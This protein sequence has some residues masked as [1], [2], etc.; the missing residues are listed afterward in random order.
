MVLY[1][2]LGLFALFAVGVF[3]FVQSGVQLPEGADEIINHTVNQPIP[4]LV[5]G[6]TSLAKSGELDIWYERIRPDG[7]SRGTVLLVMGHNSTSML[8]SA[9]FYQPFVDQG[10]EVIRYDNRD[11]GLSSWVRKWDRK[12]PYSLE[13]MARDGIAVLDDAGVNKAH[14]I[15]ASMGGMIAQ[16]MA[17]SH[18]ERIE[19]LTSIMSTGYMMDP[20]I[21]PVPKWFAQNFVRFGIRYLMTGNIKGGPKFF[22]AILQTLRGNGPYDIDVKGASETMLYETQKRR[23]FNKRAIYQ[24]GKAIEVSGSRLEELSK[25]KTRTL[26][27]HGK[28]DPLIIFDH[29]E[30]YAAV[31]PHADKLFIEGMGHDIPLIYLDQVH[32]AIFKNVGITKAEKS[33]V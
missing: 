30:K 31:M 19:S 13:D 2:S 16:R 12:N 5:K 22:V 27:V 9:H 8:W 18:D 25:L 11:V 33:L 26:I 20:E 1:V 10:Y 7:E 4:Q 21:A 17:I 14:V 24:Q 15:G 32:K 6:Q 28:A 23:G 3:Y 29:A